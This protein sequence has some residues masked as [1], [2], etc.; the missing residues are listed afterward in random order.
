M[1]WLK[2]IMAML[3]YTKM[4]KPI[5]PFLFCLAAAYVYKQ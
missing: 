2:P 1:T 3:R 4:N 5:N